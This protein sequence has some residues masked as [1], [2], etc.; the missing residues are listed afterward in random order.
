MIKLVIDVYML[1]EMLRPLRPLR[2][3]VVPLACCTNHLTSAG[4]P[5]G[6]QPLTSIKVSLRSA[7]QQQ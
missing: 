7:L 4:L 2:M 1:L 6:K 3:E 5:A